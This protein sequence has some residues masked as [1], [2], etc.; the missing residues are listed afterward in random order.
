MTIKK[1]APLPTG[2]LVVCTFQIAPDLD[3]IEASADNK[4]NSV[5]TVARLHQR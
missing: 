5:K 4:R 1:K 3:A 2:P